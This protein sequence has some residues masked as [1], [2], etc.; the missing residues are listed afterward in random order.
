LEKL[1]SEFKE[2]FLKEIEPEVKS[3]RDLLNKYFPPDN[4][5]ED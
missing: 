5:Y 3:L 2:A 1:K 4:D